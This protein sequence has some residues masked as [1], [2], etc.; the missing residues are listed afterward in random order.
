MFSIQLEY[1]NNIGR[2]QGALSFLASK[3][4]KPFGPQQNDVLQA[5]VG[6]I[7]NYY[8]A[9]LLSFSND[10]N[11]IDALQ[12][13]RNINIL[14]SRFVNETLRAEVFDL[15]KPDADLVELVDDMLNDKQYTE[16]PNL[17]IGK[18]KLIDYVN[19][20]ISVEGLNQ[21]VLL[22]KVTQSTE[23]FAEDGGPIATHKTVIDRNKNSVVLYSRAKPQPRVRKML[24]LKE[25]RSLVSVV[26]APDELLQRADEEA[27][28]RE[29]QEQQRN[30]EKEKKPVGSFANST[31]VDMGLIFEVKI[32]L[33]PA[34]HSNTMWRELMFLGV[35]V[36]RKFLEFP[37]PETE[38]GNRSQFDAWKVFVENNM[39]NSDEK[40]MLLNTIEAARRRLIML[41]ENYSDNRIA[42][43]DLFL[44]E[45]LRECVKNADLVELNYQQSY[46]SSARRYEVGFGKLQKTLN[47]LYE[48]NYVHVGA[49]I[50]ENAARFARS[51]NT[52]VDQLTLS[53][54]ALTSEI[55][56]AYNDLLDVSDRSIDR[57]FLRADYLVESDVERE[58]LEVYKQDAPLM[59]SSGVTLKSAVENEIKKIPVEK[60]SGSTVYARRQQSQ[61]LGSVY[62]IGILRRDAPESSTVTFSNGSTLK[63]PVEAVE[64]DN[65]ARLF[66]L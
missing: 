56:L 55:L 23:Y 38:I 66:A 26:A 29:R 37:R 34:Q 7:N 36:Y 3:F 60:R 25:F 24:L 9:C 5:L 16:W 2:W 8:E 20:I 21:C 46:V 12:E 44:S 57:L 17:T 35:T 28:E 33:Y 15:T 43:Y 39:V 63:F 1:I 49:L 18:Q 61:L 42:A 4:L 41:L 58:L 52:Y 19:R 48:L 40:T 22:D 47:L 14:V 31:H 10:S 59:M 32:N 27:Q 13:Q 64:N 6:V 62:S 45:L 53:D 50:N 51:L 54:D 65:V 30:T 11:Y